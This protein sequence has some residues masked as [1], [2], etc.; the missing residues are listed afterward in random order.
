MRHIYTKT[1]CYL[2]ETLTRNPAALFA[3]S[4]NAN[5][6]SVLLSSVK[7]V[8]VLVDSWD[9]LTGDVAVADLVDVQAGNFTLE[10]G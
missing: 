6:V 7:A 3:K 2:S 9:P 5:C 1:L 8:L 4:T 10:Y